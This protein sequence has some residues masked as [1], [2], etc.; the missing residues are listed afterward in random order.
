MKLFLIIIFSFFLTTLFGQNYSPFKTS[1]S[2]RFQ[3]QFNP[4]DNN[5]FFYSIQT[6]TINNTLYFKQYL[7]KSNELT[8]VMGTICEGWGG[9]LQAVADTSWLG[10][11][12][13]YDLINQRLLLSN[14]LGEELNFNFNLNLG[15]SALFYQ[16]MDENYYIKYESLTSELI[17][18]SLDLIKT[19]TVWKYDDLGNLGNSTLNGFELKL[20]LNLG[21]VSFINC[22]TFPSEEKG[23][24]LMGQLNPTIGYYQM[25]YDEAFPWQTGDLIQLKGVNLNY[26]PFSSTSIYNLLNVT[27]RTETS[28]SVWIY[29]NS[30]IQKI[31]YPPGW[32]TEFYP[33]PHCWLYTNPIVYRKGDNVI[34]QPQNM[35]NYTGTTYYADSVNLCGYKE[36]I[37]FVGSFENY[38]DSCDCF[39]PYDG[40]SSSVSSVSFVQN[41]GMYKQTVTEYGPMTSSLQSNVIYSNIG[42]VECGTPIFLGIKELSKQ[43][44][45]QP[46]PTEDILEINSSF[47]IESLQVINMQGV[48]CLS[49]VATGFSSTLQLNQL[50]PGVYFLYIQGNGGNKEIVKILKS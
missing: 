43:V 46:N 30:T 40:F 21:L 42:G 23:L 15:D 49:S 34:I 24:I 3:N 5:F 39:V 44:S 17:L 41:I 18:D 28:D 9:G 4:E 38:C 32:P 31:Y 14:Y 1:T 29:Y 2:K 16:A 45:V 26:N 20:G 19:F 13:K 7:Q 35:T 50:V 48:I 36:K 6:N 22:H 37:N 11:E 10:R 25:T 8:D 12:I 27:N 47:E 33:D